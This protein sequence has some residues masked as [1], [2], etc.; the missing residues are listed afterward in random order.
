MKRSSLHKEHLQKLNLIAKKSDPNL[1]VSSS[2]IVK[3][4]I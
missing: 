2:T 1:N 4:S 3:K